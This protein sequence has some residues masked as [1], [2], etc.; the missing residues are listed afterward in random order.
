MGDVVLQQEDA[1]NEGP[2]EEEERDLRTG[3]ERENIVDH[4]DVADQVGHYSEDRSGDCGPV[5]VLLLPPIEVSRDHAD[6]CAHVP[7]LVLY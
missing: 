2:P 5:E 6:G 3:L 1:C 4:D 7:E